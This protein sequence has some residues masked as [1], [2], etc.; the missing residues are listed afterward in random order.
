MYNGVAS[1]YMQ[2]YKDIWEMFFAIFLLLFLFCDHFCT[3][4]TVQQLHNSH[5]FLRKNVAYLYIYM[6]VKLH[7][8]KHI[9]NTTIICII[10]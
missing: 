6:Y 1:G 3:A 10:C 5:L 9:V 8:A 2:K 4:A 7:R